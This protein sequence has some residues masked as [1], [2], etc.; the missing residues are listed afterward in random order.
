MFDRTAEPCNEQHSTSSSLLRCF[1][2]LVGLDFGHFSEAYC[3]ND[4]FRS[5]FRSVDHEANALRWCWPF[6]LPHDRALPYSQ[7]DL[8]DLQYSK[9]EGLLFPEV[10]RSAK[11]RTFFWSQHAATPSGRPINAR[12]IRGLHQEQ[13]RRDTPRRH[14]SG[15]QQWLEGRSPRQRRRQSL[16]THKSGQR[17]IS[18][19]R[20][21]L[22][23]AAK[24]IRYAEVVDQGS[25]VPHS[26]EYSHLDLVPSA[27][28]GCTTA[29]Q[30]NRH[31]L[32][33]RER[34]LLLQRMYARYEALDRE[35]H[36]MEAPHL[37][38]APMLPCYIS[39]NLWHS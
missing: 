13:Y 5:H 4:V 22:D 6:R 18:R 15:S 38:A 10:P 14:P 34:H 16:N 2:S 33:F 12:P 37:R 7:L 31:N 30:T 39:C 8:E 9:L 26:N 28:A 11:I 20:A 1:K 29:G 19:R 17:N 24:D 35:L 3:A 36:E 23:Q 25:M 32:P 21:R 27:S